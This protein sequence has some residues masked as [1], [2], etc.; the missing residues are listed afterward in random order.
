[1]IAIQIDLIEADDARDSLDPGRIGIAHGR[2]EEHLRGRPPQPRGFRVHDGR[3]RN[4]FFEKAN[5]S[6]DLTEAPLVVLIVGVLAAITVAR[7]PG[8]H[9][10]DGRSF[11]DEQETQFVFEPL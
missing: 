8:H 10:G 6:V 7:G 1:V 2:A 5:P 3:G 4:A 9:L 11:P